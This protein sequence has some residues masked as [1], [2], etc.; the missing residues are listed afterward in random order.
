M[1]YRNLHA[2]RHGAGEGGSGFA[3]P[4]PHPQVTKTTSPRCHSLHVPHIE[5]WEDALAQPRTTAQGPWPYITPA[6]TGRS[7]SSLFTPPHNRQPSPA[8]WRQDRAT[9]A[10]CVVHEGPVS[11]PCD[12]AIPVDVALRRLFD[13]LSS[14]KSLYEEYQQL[15]QRQAGQTTSWAES[16]TLDKLWRDLITRH[17]DSARFRDV[18]DKLDARL[19]S[20]KGSLNATQSN[21]IGHGSTAK[22]DPVVLERRLRAG[23][24]AELHCDGLLELTHRARMERMACTLLVEELGELTAMLDPNTHPV[25]YFDSEEEQAESMKGKG[26]ARARPNTKG[27]STRKEKAAVETEGDAPNP[28]SSTNNLGQSSDGV[29]QDNEEIDYGQEQEQQQ[30]GDDQAWNG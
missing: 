18:T 5:S 6:S 26:S 23:K 3:W 8:T 2:R 27:Q 14:C 15:F 19:L 29:Q 4:W 16:G 17:G 9:A 24:K 30:G 1:T 7:S 12:I 25:L 21:G 13:A 10:R 22:H 20:L 11:S 28:F